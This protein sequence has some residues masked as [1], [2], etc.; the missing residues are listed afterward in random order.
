MKYAMVFLR[1]DPVVCIEFRDQDLGF[2]VVKGVDK[3][4]WLRKGPI[5]V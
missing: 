2:Q 4:M 5:P 1:M 3:P